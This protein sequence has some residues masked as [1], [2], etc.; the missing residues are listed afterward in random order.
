MPVLTR[1]LVLFIGVHLSCIPCHAQFVSP[2]E[3]TP[4]DSTT[5]TVVRPILSEDQAITVAEPILFR[6]YGQA[7]IVA[8]R[9]Y[10]CEKIGQ[11]WYITGSLGGSDKERR[12][13]EVTTIEVV[14]GGVFSIYLD[15][16]DGHVVQITHG[17]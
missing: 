14:R 1:M 7:N 17:K 10:K 11:L 16:L 12:H 9:P 13:G 8:Q 6:I 15:A 3:Q 4:L 5:T 2:G